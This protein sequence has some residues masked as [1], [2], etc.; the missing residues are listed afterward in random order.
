MAQ[1]SSVTFDDV[2]FHGSNFIHVASE[3]LGLQGV[4]MA[5]GKP[6]WYTSWPRWREDHGQRHEQC[7]AKRFLILAFFLAARPDCYHRLTY[8]LVFC[9][10]T[11]CLL[12]SKRK[13]AS[14]WSRKPG[15]KIFKFN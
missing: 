6:R 9:P 2:A 13:S 10:T 8:G 5:E 11:D 14:V 4:V 12:S 3:E 7:K 1:P 15:L